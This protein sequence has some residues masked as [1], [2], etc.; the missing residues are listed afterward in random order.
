[1]Y[2]VALFFTFTF[3]PAIQ[4]FLYAL[5]RLHPKPCPH[6]PRRILAVEEILI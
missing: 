4:N 2:I 6:Q 3:L 5:Q 1:M